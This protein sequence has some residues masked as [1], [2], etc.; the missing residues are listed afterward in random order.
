ML[1]VKYLQNYIIIYSCCSTVC[2]IVILYNIALVRENNFHNY[3]I[4]F[5]ILVR[6]MRLYL[7]IPILVDIVENY[8]RYHLISTIIF[9][10][11][12]SALELP[13]ITSYRPGTTRM[14]LVLASH[15]SKL[16]RGR[17]MLTVLLSPGVSSTCL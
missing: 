15:T 5:L 16:V 1:V 9:F 6:R 13:T 7:C 3:G 2:T 4:I 11:S 14:V 10:R 8:L 17:G 12:R